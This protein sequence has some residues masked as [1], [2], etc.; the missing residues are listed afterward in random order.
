MQAALIQA[1]V[2]YAIAAVV[3]LFVALMI[4]GLFKIVRRFSKRDRS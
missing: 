4:H 1:V 3:S 2:M